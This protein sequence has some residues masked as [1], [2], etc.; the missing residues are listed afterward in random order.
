LHP[1]VK[2]VSWLKQ[3]NG[4]YEAE[5]TQNKKDFGVSIDSL[6]NLKETEM[7]MKVSEWSKEILDYVAK[8]FPGYK[9][10]EAAQITY[11]DGKPTYEAEISKGKESFDLVF[12]SS[13]K[14]VKKGH[15]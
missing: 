7:D 6:G 11:T 8:N 9:M 12:D 10:T 2:D 14:Y 4:G 5:F 13:F 1:D 15:F 3:K